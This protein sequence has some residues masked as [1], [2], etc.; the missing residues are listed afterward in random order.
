MGHF[1]TFQCVETERHHTTCPALFCPLPRLTLHTNLARGWP[2]GPWSRQTW[3]A[4]G[5]DSGH[6]R[7]SLW[8][9]CGWV[10]RRCDLS[11][12]CFGLESGC[13][14]KS[15][16]GYVQQSIF[17][18]RGD[19]PEVDRKEDQKEAQSEQSRS[20]KTRV[21]RASI[22]V[23]LEVGWWATQ[24]CDEKSHGAWPSARSSVE[25]PA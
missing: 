16:P 12:C 24:G 9:G 5:S 14:M 17:H 25:S 21:I 8:P 7:L 1:C 11:V 18:W 20:R 23:S 19:G 2:M 13:I 10:A 15:L 3:E 6:G 4:Q 22:K